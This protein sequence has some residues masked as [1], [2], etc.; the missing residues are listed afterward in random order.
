MLSVVDIL[1]L[2]VDLSFAVF[3]S[4][5]KLYAKILICLLAF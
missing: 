4:V 3:G 5:L 1:K 2:E